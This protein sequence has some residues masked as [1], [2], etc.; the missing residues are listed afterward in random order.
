MKKIL[1][2][3]PYL[4]ALIPQFIFNNYL[5]IVITTFLVGLTSRFYIKNKWVLVKM[6]LLELLTFTIIF[7]IVG[8]RIFYL[9]EILLN[10]NLSESLL[11]IIFPIFNA[12]NISILFFTGYMLGTLLFGKKIATNTALS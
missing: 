6:F 7:L 9:D 3:W 12:L 11:V 8:D 10:L 5:L 4:I 1:N 2:Y